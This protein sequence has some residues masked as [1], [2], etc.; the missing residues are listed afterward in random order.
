MIPEEKSAISYS[1]TFH[2]PSC[3]LT[4]ECLKDLYRLLDARVRE[5]SL[6]ETNNIRQTTDQTDED[7]QETIRIIDESYVVTVQITTQDGQTI[8]GSSSSILDSAEM[9]QNISRIDFDTGFEFD[10]RFKLMPRNRI[11]LNLDFSKFI[12]LDTTNPT[13]TPTPNNSQLFMSGQDQN[14]IIPAYEKIKHFLESRRNTTLWLHKRNTYDILLIL[15]GM[16]IG[17]WLTYRLTETLRNSF[18]DASIVLEVAVL[19]YVFVLW[20]YFFRFLFFYA[21]WAWPLVEYTGASR[22]EAR[23]HRGF[24]RFL[25]GGVFVGLVYDFFKQAF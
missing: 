9:P 5:A 20:L 10:K 4:N 7:L 11:V 6:N 15:F 25:A 24:W 12:P 2:I 21:K 8:V 23:L 18:A 17:F 14:W 22:N 19:V 13:T 16:P 1:R 3:A